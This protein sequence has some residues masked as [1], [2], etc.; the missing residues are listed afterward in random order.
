MLLPPHDTNNAIQ[1]QFV[2]YTFASECEHIQF[3]NYVIPFL[4]SD[5]YANVFLPVS[6]KTLLCMFFVWDKIARMITATLSADG[7]VFK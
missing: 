6:Y 5:L 4:E 3:C 1:A 2:D 7:N